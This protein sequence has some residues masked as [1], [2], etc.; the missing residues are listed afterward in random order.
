M[1][2]IVRSYAIVQPITMMVHPFHTESAL[3]AVVCSWRLEPFAQPALFQDSFL[4]SFC[5]TPASWQ[6]SW[7][8]Q[9][10]MEKAVGCESIEE[11]DKEMP[12]VLIAVPG[13]E[14][15]EVYES[16]P[17]GNDCHAK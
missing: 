17:S 6:V 13:T 16:G 3:P 9:A 7:V 8:V 12:I 4:A 1:F 2:V 11:G 10:G 15:L 14:R 5:R